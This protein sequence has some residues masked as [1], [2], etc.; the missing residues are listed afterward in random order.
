MRLCTV[1]RIHIYFGHN[2]QLNKNEI[3]TIFI[4]D[5]CSRYNNNNN[6]NN[7]TKKKTE[8]HLKIC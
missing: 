3:I 1:Q 8:L 6:N 2:N 7:N 4:N 5:S